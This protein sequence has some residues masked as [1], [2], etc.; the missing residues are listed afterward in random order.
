MT[1]AGAVDGK[2]YRAFISYSH[3]DAAFA[4]RLH[5]RLETYVLPRRLGGERRLTPIFKDREEL[6]AAH[7]LSAQVRSALA[8]SNCLIVV[9]SPAAAVSPWVGREIDTFRELH[10]DRPI[11]AALIGGE[12]A[13]ALHPALSARGVEPLAADFRKT[14]DG[15]R[16]ALLKLVAGLAG[17]GV[18]RLIQRD[19]QRRLWGVMALTAAALVAVLAM[20]G[21]TLFALGAQTEAERQRAEAESLV[22]FML[23]DLREELKGQ[24]DL[25]VRT[26]ANRRALE[27]FRKQDLTRL[28]ASALQKQARLFHA[29][30][31]D[32]LDRGNLKAA[33]SSF[34]HAEKV[35]RALVEGSPKDPD[36]LWAHAQSAYWRGRAAHARR[37]LPAARLAWVEYG[38]LANELLAADPKAR[39]SLSEVA[40]AQNTLCALA[41][42]A[43]DALGAVQACQLAVAKMTRAAALAPSDRAAKLDVA[44]NRGWLADAYILTGNLHAA[45]HERLEQVKALESLLV[46]DPSNSQLLDSWGTAQRSLGKICFLEGDYAASKQHLRLVLHI[47]EPLAARDPENITW[48]GQIEFAA[49]ALNTINLASRNKR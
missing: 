33:E 23:T 40:Y 42:E 30:G 1:G 16:L 17:V 26:A 6:P 36:R 8:L 32:E 24:G 29:M 11:L 43:K 28:P 31:E 10:P 18:D 41:V 45:R 22:E 14:G 46:G 34:E 20:G 48:R 37:Q 21:M 39:R 9:C 19:A 3:K 15:E 5:R 4:R 25:K 47:F 13:E 44:T 27:Y 2:R 35:T 38:R 12:P 49:R 7:D